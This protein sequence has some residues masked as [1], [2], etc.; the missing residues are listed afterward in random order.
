VI[1]HEV[2]VRIKPGVPRESIDRT[3]GEIR[4]LI[5]EIPGVVRV[6]IGANNASKYRHAMIVV[7]LSDEVALRRFQRHALQARAVRLVT[8]MAEST[9]MGSYLVS[10][11][12]HG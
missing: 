10:S 1:R 8:R 12:H 11:E 5:G 7:D 9:A 2:I 3:L 6:R 4:D